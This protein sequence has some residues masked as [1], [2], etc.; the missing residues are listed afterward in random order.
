[1]EK[2]S[3]ECSI[4]QRSLLFKQTLERIT[5]TK[6]KQF[7]EDLFSH[8]YNV[9]MDRDYYRSIVDGSWPD[10]D[11]VIKQRREDRKTK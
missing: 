10:S 4:C 1:M 11:E 2:P 8:L 7:F 5:E 9:E 3:C 6:D